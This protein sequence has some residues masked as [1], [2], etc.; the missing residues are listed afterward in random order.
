MSSTCGTRQDQPEALA[1]LEGLK[2]ELEVFHTALDEYSRLLEIS[3][4]EFE[5]LVLLMQAR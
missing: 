5:K 4:A 3:T 2:G 1:K